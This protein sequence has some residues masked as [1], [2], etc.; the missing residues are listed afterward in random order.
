MR[1]EDTAPRKQ[2]KRGCPRA[3]RDSQRQPI[4]FRLQRSERDNRVPMPLSRTLILW[5]RK[6]DFAKIPSFVHH[7]GV[8]K[9]RDILRECPCSS[10]T[11]MAHPNNTHPY[12]NPSATG[13]WDTHL[14]PDVSPME[15]PSYAQTPYSLEIDWE[16]VL[17]SAPRV[18]Q[19][20]DLCAPFQPTFE[21]YGKRSS[22]P[23][24]GWRLTY[25]L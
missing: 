11:Q 19:W 4:R 7:W 25:G 3:P 15:E 17:Q 21:N 5:P 2:R 20:S 22:R 10:P 18:G 13:G 8:F 14:P 1:D 16:M 9:P 23:L 12:Y 24:V 6:V